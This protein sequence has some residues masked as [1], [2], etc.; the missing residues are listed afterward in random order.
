MKQESILK[1]KQSYNLH[2]LSEIRY[3][4]VTFVKLLEKKIDFLFLPKWKK[5]IEET[6]TNL[7]QCCII[8]A[9]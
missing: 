6:K 8:N 2:C 4:F 7:L 5:K 9:V 1:E 3:I